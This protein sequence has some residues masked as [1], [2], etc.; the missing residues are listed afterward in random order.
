MPE[1]YADTRFEISCTGDDMSVSGEAARVVHVNDQI[2]GAVYIGRQHGWKRLRRS[3]WANPYKIGAPSPHPLIADPIGRE[4]SLFG[5]SILLWGSPEMLRRLPELR[6][7]PLACWCRHD[8]VPLR[9][10]VTDEGPD[11]RCHGDVL[12]HALRTYTD[13]E[14]LEK[15]DELELRSV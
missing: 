15:A 9:N 10:G 1:P 7:K 11:N 14:L 13:E 8:H 12:V 6:G 4:G 5:Y 2:P 3:F